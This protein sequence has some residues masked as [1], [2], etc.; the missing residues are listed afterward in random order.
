MLGE[1]RYG[2]GDDGPEAG[3]RLGILGFPIAGA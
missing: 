1:A 3:G 2:V